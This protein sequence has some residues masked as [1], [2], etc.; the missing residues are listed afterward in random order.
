MVRIL[1]LIVKFIFGHFISLL[2][3]LPSMRMLQYLVN[4]SRKNTSQVSF[5][6]KFNFLK[7]FLTENKYLV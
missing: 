3:C 1:D 2:R 5:K 7:I 6:K 4:Y